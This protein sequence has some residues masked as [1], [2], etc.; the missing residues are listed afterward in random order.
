MATAA[1]PARE[2]RLSRP[3]L[4]GSDAIVLIGAVVAFLAGWAIK[5]WHDDRVSSSTIAGVTVAYPRGWV[6]FGGAPPVVLQA[7]S[8]EN[9]LMAVILSVQ[10]TNQTDVL[11]AIATGAPAIG[12]DQP[13]Y[14]QLANETTEVDGIPAVRTDYAYVVAGTGG[15]SVPVVIRGRQVSWITNGQLYSFAV[16]GPEAEWSRV[17]SEANRLVKK[18]DISA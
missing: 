6:D 8:D 11:L 18:I 15:R 2:M 10:P 1:V 14:V 9:P 5:D 7:V 16:E 17:R 4:T 13:N 12:S 3:R